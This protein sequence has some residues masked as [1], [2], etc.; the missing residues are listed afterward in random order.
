MRPR[1]LAVTPRKRVEN[2]KGRDQTLESTF[3]ALGEEAEPAVSLGPIME[4]RS[5]DQ[6][7]GR[8]GGGDGQT[9]KVGI[10]PTLK[11]RE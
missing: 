9:C 3:K 5:H 10:I 11:I 4:I 7:N 8:E 6:Q 2:K 1:S